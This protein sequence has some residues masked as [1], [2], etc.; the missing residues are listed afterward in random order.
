MVKGL[1]S[2]SL[3]ILIA[4][5]AWTI[6]AAAEDS[7]Q[8]L[9][10]N[11]CSQCHGAEGRGGKGPRLV[12]FDWSYEQALALVRRPICDM[13]PIPETE[14]SDEEVSQIVVYLKSIK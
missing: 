2:G 1:I 4:T 8:R 12:P 3:V 9:Y 6:G 5:C 13:P 11:R 7:G 14:V 10:E